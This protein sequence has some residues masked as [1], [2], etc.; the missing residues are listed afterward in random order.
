MSKGSKP[1]PITDYTSYTANWAQ[2]FTK[3]E[4]TNEELDEIDME[5]CPYCGIRTSDLCDEP[6]NDCEQAITKVHGEYLNDLS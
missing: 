1:R 2:T 6:Q 3:R 5:Q 4:P